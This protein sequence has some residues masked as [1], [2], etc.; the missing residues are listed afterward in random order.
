[1][2]KPIIPLAGMAVCSLGGIAQ[3]SPNFLIIQCDHLTQRVVGAY[4]ETQGVTPAIDRV[5]QQGV[6]F[7]NAYVGCPLSQPSRA[8]LWTGLMPHQTNVRSNTDARVNKPVPEN[9]PT[10]GSLFVA[11]GYEAVHFGKTHDMGAL[12]GFTHKEPVPQPFEDPEFPVNRDSFLDVGTCSDVVDYLTDPPAKPF[13]CIADFQN[14]HN[15]CGYIGANEG[16]HTDRPISGELPPLPANFEPEDWSNLPVPIQYICCNHRRMAQASPWNE[17]NYR[18]YIAAF[19]H[20]TRMVDKQI[21]QVLNALYSTPAGRNTIVVILADHGDGMASH[22]MVTKQ[23]SFYEEIINVPFIFAGPGIRNMKKPTD[24]FLTQPTLDLLPTLCELAGIE[25]PSDKPGISLAPFLQGKKQKKT[26]PYA[27]SEWHTE[28]EEIITPG[29]MIRSP[30]YKY[31]H[32]LEGNGEEL[33]DLEK[34]RGERINLA[35]DPAYARVLQQHRALLDDYIIRTNDD[36]RSLKVEADS[37]WRE[38]TP[39]YPNHK[40]SNSAWNTVKWR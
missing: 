35:H 30:R 23:V 3:Q 8:A 13:I 40:G 15:I 1:M 6:V 2:I 16:V 38:H 9:I 19:H 25:V 10:L 22:R 26:R 36:Y 39:G 12:R 11:G 33:Y 21:D 4:G 34:D 18:H 31:T 28:Y 14:P 17:T 32:Y 20:Y 29:R 27:V 5:A 24:K 37:C 7:A